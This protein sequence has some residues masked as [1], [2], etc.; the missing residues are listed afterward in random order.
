[1][2]YK[3]PSE[4]DVASTVVPENILSLTMRDKTCTYLQEER[5]QF[6]ARYVIN[7]K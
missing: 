5:L 7:I 2:R 3:Y 6:Y 1:M 4:I